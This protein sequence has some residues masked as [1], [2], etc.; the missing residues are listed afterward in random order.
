MA[1]NKH[2]YTHAPLHNH[3]I[4]TGRTR[5]TTTTTINKLGGAFTSYVS[6]WHW[7]ATKVYFEAKREKDGSWEA[8]TTQTT[9][10]FSLPDHTQLLIS[11]TWTA[12]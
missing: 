7:I 12:K 2:T 4:N 10:S 1:S 5:I 11:E 8:F 3:H 6:M 9:P